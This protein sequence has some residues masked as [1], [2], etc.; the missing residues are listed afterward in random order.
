[1]IVD[2][3]IRARLLTLTPVTDLVNQRVFCEI[4]PQS[5]TLPAILVTRI[6]QI[7]LMHFRG[8]V[9]IYR[10][11][12]QVESRALSR[13]VAA[14]VDAAVQGDGL[15]SDATGLLGFKGSV[16]SPAF[17]FRAILPFGTR[18]DYDPEENR[19]FRVFR[20]FMCHFEG[21]Q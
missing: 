8:P 15:G 2:T 4:W 5:P 1:M 17:V 16:G 11:L 21:T 13:Q 14:E 18:Q 6:S 12:V 19:H 10:A 20:E 9:G 7:E 3:A